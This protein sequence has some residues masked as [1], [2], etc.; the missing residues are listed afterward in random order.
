MVDGWEA[1]GRQ[2]LAERSRRWPTRSAFA[3]ACHLSKRVLDD[4]ETGRRPGNYSDTTLARIEAALG[5]EPG[6]IR[7]RAEGR[8][9][10]RSPDRNLRRLQ[11]AWPHLSEDA[12]SILA[13]LAERGLLQTLAQ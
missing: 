8:R 11:D 7:A 2:I 10:R 13:D 12:R 9:P 3:D 4:I 5:W 6:E 1:V